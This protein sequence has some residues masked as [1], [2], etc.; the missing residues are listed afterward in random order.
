MIT[1][2]KPNSTNALVCELI[3]KATSEWNIDKL[4][5]WFIP[6]D[7]DAILGIPLSSSNTQDRLIWAENRSGKFTVKS[8]Y[9]LVLEEK[10]RVARAN[11]SDETT[12]RKIWKSIWLL[13]I[14]QKIKHFA[15]NAVLGILATKSNLEKRKVTSNGICELCGDN[16]ETVCHLLWSCDHAKEVWNNSKFALPF[17]ISMQWNFLYVVANLQRCDHLRLG[18]MKQFITVC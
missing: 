7:R 4:N 14:P 10:A 9:A 11:C 13:K 8:A 12:R 17:E 1:K 18:Q 16:E 6:E 2:E 15:W 5:S 3:N